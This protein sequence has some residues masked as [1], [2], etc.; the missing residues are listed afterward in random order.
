MNEHTLLKA[1]GD[2]TRLDVLRLLARRE[3]TVAALLERLKMEQSALSHHLK[4][5]REAGLVTSRYE[6]AHVVYA[7]AHPR[8]GAFLKEVT[9]TAEAVD[10]VCRCVECGGTLLR[11]YPRAGEAPPSTTTRGARRD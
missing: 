2:P 10:G 11:P 9:E 4:V 7:L 1:L 3:R 8:L 6:E 5:L